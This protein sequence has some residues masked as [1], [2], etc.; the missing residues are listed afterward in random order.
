M[1]SPRKLSSNEVAALVD[2]LMDMDGGDNED[3][4]SYRSY[5]F[6]SDDL[7]LLGE[8]HALR[9]INDRFCRIAR[10][11]FLPMLRI[12]P[13]ISSFPPEIRTFDD[14][15][16]SQDPFLSLTNCRIEELRGNQLM[17]VPPEF[18]SLLTDAYYGGA[19]RPLHSKRNE[20]TA[21]ESRVIEIVTDNLNQ[22]LRL[23]WRDLMPLNF[24]LVS[25][26]ENLQFAAFVDGDEMVVNCSFMVQLPDMEPASFDILYPLQTLKPISSQLRSRMQSDYVADDRSWRERLIRAILSIPLDVTAQL[27]E[28][29]TTLGRL[30]ALKDDDIVPVQL[31]DRVLIRVEGLPMFEA[32]AGD[33]NGKSAVN[34]TRRL[35]PEEMKK[36]PKN[37]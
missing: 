6:G 31:N 21:T 8:F 24:T 3:G 25:R 14:Y 5:Q 23:A 12:Q 32:Q 30:K 36:V 1:K 26:E 19:I 34:L 35:D 37:E 29:M 33:V 10:S 13:R 2:G 18:I 15:R 7:S 22:A 4:I 28:P 17:V 20:F 27:A 9:M 16:D 11:V